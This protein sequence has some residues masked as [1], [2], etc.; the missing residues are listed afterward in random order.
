[1]PSQESDEEHRRRRHPDAALPDPQHC[2]FYY[3]TGKL[4]FVRP[5]GT[6]VLAQWMLLCHDCADEIQGQDVGQALD[7]GR[8]EI[9]C[10]RPWPEDLEV[11]IRGHLH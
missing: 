2:H 8:I 4:E 7:Q 5:D 9:G 1:M 11:E 3:F 6:R 10:D